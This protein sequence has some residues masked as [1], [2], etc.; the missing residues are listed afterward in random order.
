MTFSSLTIGASALYAAQRAVEVAAHNVANATNTGYTRQRLTL[1]ASTPSYGTPGA[2]GSGDVGTGVTIVSLS[3]LRDRLADV[4][5]RSE[6]GTAGAASARADTLGRAE[7]VLGTYSDGAPEALSAFLSAWDSLSTNPADSAARTSVLA[8]GTNLAESITS[9]SQRLDEVS[10]EVTLR[11]GDDVD[12][13][14]GLL[15]AVAGLNAAIVKAKTEQREP[16]DLQDQRDTA[17]DR[18]AAL[19]G[20]RIES[21]DDGSVTVTTKSGV[22]LVGGQLAATLTSSGSSPV[23]VA[24]DGEPAVLAGEIGGYVSAA[25]SDIP[26]YRAQ[27]DVV[28]QQL[29]DVVNTAH[30]AGVGSDGSTDLDFFT[31]TDASDLAV[32]SDLTAA[33]LGAG[34]SSSPGDGNGALGVAAALRTTRDADGQSVGDMLRAVGSRVG[35]AAT[36]AARGA[37]TATASVTSAQAARASA[38]G[39]SVDEEMVDLVKFQHSYEAAARVI[40]IADGM[41]DKLINEM[42]R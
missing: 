31:G 32:N 8:A 42:V 6:A 17:L 37:R 27:L 36:D 23:S 28:A 11:V 12:E 33:K 4:A 38:D 19:T 40:S 29:R 26:A 34:R 15:K 30:R 24:V 13:L 9:A 10:D 16:N 20:A 35:Q 14:N 41:L 39:V 22:Q 7:S 25:T 21:L 1:Q 18:I 2:V 3:R 5:Y